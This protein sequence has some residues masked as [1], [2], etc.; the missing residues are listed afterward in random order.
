MSRHLN[1]EM[2]YVVFDLAR[3]KLQMTRATQLAMHSDFGQI[4]TRLYITAMRP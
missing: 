1:T 4:A 2:A 3:H